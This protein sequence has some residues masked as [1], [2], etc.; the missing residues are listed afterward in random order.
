MA[1]AILKAQLTKSPQFR[2]LQQQGR[3]AR[4]ELQGGMGTGECWPRV[5]WGCCWGAAG[6]F[7]VSLAPPCTAARDS[8]AQCGGTNAG[9]LLGLGA[10]LIPGVTALFVPSLPQF[11]TGWRGNGCPHPQPPPPSAQ[12]A[13]QGEAAPRPCPGAG[14]VAAE[15]LRVLHGGSPGRAVRG[16]PGV[17][18]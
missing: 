8:G 13:A 4:G 9:T 17:R 16:Y 3:G 10:A 14:R 6:H 5:G 15:H 1:S 18:S 11:P 12:R 7:L 2:R